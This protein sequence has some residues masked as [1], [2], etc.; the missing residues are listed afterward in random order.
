MDKEKDLGVHVFANF[1]WDVYT[2][3]I[4]SKANRMPG[5]LKRT[6]SFLTNNSV[7]ILYLTHVRSQLCYA[8]EVWSPNTVKL[9]NRLES[10][11]R[12]A[13][14]WILNSNHGERTYQQR[15]IC[16]DLLPLCY[17]REISDLVFFFKAPYGST[18]LDINTFVSL[19][20][21]AWT[22]LCQTLSL[23]LKVPLCKSITFKASYNNRIKIWNYIC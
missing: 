17:E 9:R 14:A 8:S 7:R 4:I 5:L 21:K 23:T 12:R 22:R 15:L 10:V 16:L 11:E 13:T 18:D 3:T 2:Y 19:S 6:C 1:K 20:N